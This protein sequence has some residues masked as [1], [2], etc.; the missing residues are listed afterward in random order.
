M[1]K[2]LFIFSLVYC[3]VITAQS[4]LSV[5]LIA[6]SDIT[7]LSL[8]AKGKDE[9][10]V[11]SDQARFGYQGGVRVRYD[12]NKLFSMQ[13]GFSLVS[14]QMGP[15]TQYYIALDPSDPNVPT[16]IESN[17]TFKN[18]QVPLLVSLYGGRKIKFG[19]TVG[20]AYNYNYRQDGE[21]TVNYQTYSK[22]YTYTAKISSNNQYLSLIGG[23]GVEYTH[24]RFIFRAE[25]TASYQV[26][27]F[28]NDWAN[29]YYR[30][31]SAGLSFSTFYKF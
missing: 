7:G 5:G 27:F 20:G 21:S 18:W 29:D 28:D 9:I 19:V 16:S 31:W 17:F 13:T 25:P 6:S 22:D 26:H 4:K 24:K 3:S 1:K 15:G 14:H 10:G 23:V 30:L 2:L 11:T 8:T 12:F